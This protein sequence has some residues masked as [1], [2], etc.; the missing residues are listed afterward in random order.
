MHGLQHVC[1]VTLSSCL[2]KLLQLSLY[3]SSLHTL[4]QRSCLNWLVEL[5]QSC[6]PRMMCK[7]P[8]S[9]SCSGLFEDTLHF[10]GGLLLSR[11]GIGGVS[12]RRCLPLQ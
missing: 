4:Q 1:V 9:C 8:V 11:A 6:Y 2:W 12:S 5:L 10:C 3:C 7:F